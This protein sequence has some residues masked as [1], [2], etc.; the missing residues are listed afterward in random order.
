MANHQ[1][2]MLDLNTGKLCRID[3]LSRQVQTIVETSDCSISH[4]ILDN[5]REEADRMGFKTD[6]IHQAPEHIEVISGVG[7]SKGSVP[8]NQVEKFYFTFM[9]KQAFKNHFVEILAASM[10]EAREAMHHHF[11][12]KWAFSYRH[13][14]FGQQIQ[15]FNLKRLATIQ[16][17]DHG[18][19]LEHR[20]FP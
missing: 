8:R 20:I 16:V 11:G 10:E 9:Q 17:I 19:S 2:I 5:A 15:E 7:E 1:H 4:F 3:V 18:S 13:E 14:G 6:H 12:D